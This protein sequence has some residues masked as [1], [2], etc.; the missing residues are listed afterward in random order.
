MVFSW[1]DDVNMK[2]FNK[3]LLLAITVFLVVIVIFST[4]TFLLNPYVSFIKHKSAYEKNETRDNLFSLCNVSAECYNY[5]HFYEYSKKYLDAYNSG[6]I[7]D[8]YN[9]NVEEGCGIYDTFLSEFLVKSI[10][11]EHIDKSELLLYF[12]KF[13]DDGFFVKIF[14]HQIETYCKSK[15]DITRVNTSLTYILENATSYRDKM[16]VY[17][18]Q[19]YIYESLGDE[20]LLEETIQNQKKIADKYYAEKEQI[21]K[22]DNTIVSA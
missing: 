14:W 5:S 19:V 16:T 9:I 22:K 6:D 7:A 11:Y 15:K 2:K 17:T 18:L 21:T 4:T 8:Y 3:K 13:E 1:K 20:E 12:S 10:I